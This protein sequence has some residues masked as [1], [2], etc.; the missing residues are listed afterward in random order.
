MVFTYK[1]W[2]SFCAS[3]NNNVCIRAK[4]IRNHN[5]K[6]QFI[7][8]KHDVETDPYKSLLLAQIEYRYQ[9]RASYYVQ[10]YLLKDRR[11]VQILKMIQ[12]LGH[13]VTYHYDVLDSQNGNWEE[14]E[15]EFQKTIN[16]FNNL[17]FD[18]LT[19]CPHGNPII[20]RDS[21]S[22]NKDFFREE[23]IKNRYPYIIDIV[24][25]F[26]KKYGDNCIYISDAGYNWKIVADISNNDVYQ[27]KSDIILKNIF[28]IHEY[29]ENGNSIII[30]THP[31]RWSRY[32]LYST[33]KRYSFL[34]IKRAAYSLSKSSIIN[35]IMSKYYHMAKHI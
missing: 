29:L 16:S 20:K 5:K 11:N 33:L 35:H 1:Y 8:L 32:S 7:I 19:V 6:Q 26:K 28:I 9:I 23:R 4:D 15:I 18:V 30:S 12:D 27:L 25:E 2:D 10:S 21:W 24:V 34:F 22:S 3:L 13:E 31:H 17:G 14:A